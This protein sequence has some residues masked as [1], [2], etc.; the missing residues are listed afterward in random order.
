M[1]ILLIEI[2]AGLPPPHVAI[3]RRHDFLQLKCL[4]NS[5]AWHVHSV[6]VLYLCVIDGTNFLFIDE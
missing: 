6:Q 2:F 1:N 3:D 5:T 4:S